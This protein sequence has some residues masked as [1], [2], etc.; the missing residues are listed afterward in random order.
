MSRELVVI[1]GKGGTGK[2]SLVA[3]FAVL[4]KDK[5]IVDADA[6]AANLHILLKP[7]IKRK[8]LFK[9]N[10]PAKIDT[11]RCIRC[12]ECR[13][14]CRFDAIRID[15]KG[16][17]V[18][19]QMRCDSCALC[20]Y[21]CPVDAIEMVESIS[22]EWY[23]SETFYGPMVHAKLYPGAEN[24]GNLVTMVKHRAKIISEENNIEYIL[25]DG[26]PGIGCPVISTISG[27]DFV[28]IV[29]EPTQSGL[30]DLRRVKEL[31]DAFKVKTGVVVN[32][33][34]LNEGITKRIKSLAEEQGS[35]FLGTI[36][37]D[38]CVLDAVI[39]REIPCEACGSLR[40]VYAEILKKAMEM[41]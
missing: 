13:R 28:V 17:Y 12:D 9:G 1:S 21:A 5:V 33:S 34:T 26:S 8:E 40:D 38:R 27:A 32:K 39:N 18:V 22:G 14:L 30:H 35:L 15:E 29:T 20:K 23:E 31:C 11:S 41:L 4:M 36:P 6:D 37:F 19:N 7:K 24:S 3:S 16:D 2:T 25:V 10:M